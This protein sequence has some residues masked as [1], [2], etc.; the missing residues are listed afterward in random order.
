MWLLKEFAIVMSM[1]S[2][3]SAIKYSIMR[4]LT[5]MVSIIPGFSL[6]NH[7]TFLLHPLTNLEALRLDRV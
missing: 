5:A 6:Y 2:L 4:D 1:L 7:T 3:K